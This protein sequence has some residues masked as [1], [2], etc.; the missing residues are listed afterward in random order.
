MLSFTSAVARIVSY[1]LVYVASVIKSSQGL[2]LLCT[3]SY[4]VHYTLSS[5]FFPPFYTQRHLAYIF[6][7]VIIFSLLFDSDK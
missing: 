5:D 1:T 4:V 3:P 2:L 7:V 6:R